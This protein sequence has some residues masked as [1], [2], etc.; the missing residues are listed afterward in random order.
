[1]TISDCFYLMVWFYNLFI[2]EKRFGS[3][4]LFLQIHVYKFDTVLSSQF[5]EGSGDE[6]FYIQVYNTVS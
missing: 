5:S 1:M 2:F 4:I 3:I 6:I